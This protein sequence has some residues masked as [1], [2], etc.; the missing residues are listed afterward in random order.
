MAWPLLA[1][2]ATTL[3]LKKTLLGKAIRAASENMESAMLV[4]IVPHRV[5]SLAFALGM[6]LAGLAGVAI[7]TVYPFDPGFGFTFSLKAMIALALGGLG[8]VGGALV[9][10]IVL[11]SVESFSSYVLGGAWADAVGYALF[12]V[13][14]LFK[15]EG[16]FASSCDR[17]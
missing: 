14:L 9:G 5:H 2:V 13:V 11:G 6:G 8:N 10:G 12:L 15:P 7:A 3:F 4:G 16:L 17:K 1:A